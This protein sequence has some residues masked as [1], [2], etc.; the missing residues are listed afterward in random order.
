MKKKESAVR[1][2]SAVAAQPVGRISAPAKV[3]SPVV[4]PS[5][6]SYHKRAP[7]ASLNSSPDSRQSLTSTIQ[8]TNNDSD[9]LQK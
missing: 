2:N 8:K 4:K 3:L 1:L 7:K 6:L 9:P 5:P